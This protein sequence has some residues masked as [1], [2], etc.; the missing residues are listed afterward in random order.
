M[1]RL[2]AG[3]ASF[4]SVQARVLKGL[5]SGLD[6]DSLGTFH[7]YLQKKEMPASILWS[8]LSLFL[9]YHSSPN[10]LVGN[11]PVHGSVHPPATWDMNACTMGSRLSNDISLRQGAQHL[12]TEV[13]SAVKALLRLQWNSLSS[14]EY[15][16]FCHRESHFPYE[17]SLT[18]SKWVKIN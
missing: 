16:Y 11:R 17:L 4:L 9:W 3:A 2:L 12:Y 7:S 6:S 18:S 13:L 10:I 5:I 15:A 14:F 1:I 8:C